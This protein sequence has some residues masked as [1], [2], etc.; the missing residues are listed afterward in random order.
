MYH[1]HDVIQFLT[2][3]PVDM[4]YDDVSTKDN[5]DEMYFCSN[6][7]FSGQI[8]YNKLGSIEHRYNVLV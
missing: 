7:F 1:V 4:L 5:I 8:Y 3:K 6:F 2:Q